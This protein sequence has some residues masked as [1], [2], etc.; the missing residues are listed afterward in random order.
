[1]DKEKC[2]ELLSDYG[3]HTNREIEAVTENWFVPAIIRQLRAE[4]HTIVSRMIGNSIY[5]Y[6]LLKKPAEKEKSLFG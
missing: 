2:L 6:G 3:L 5:C 1:M 4:G